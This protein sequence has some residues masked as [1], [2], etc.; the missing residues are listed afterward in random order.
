MKGNIKIEGIV[1]KVYDGD[2]PTADEIRLLLN[3]EPHSADAGLIISSADTIN[4]LASNNKA[5]V[6][7]QIGINCAP[8]PRNC[9]FCAFAAKNKVFGESMEVSFEDAV[10]MA[11]NGEREGKRH[12]YYG[13]R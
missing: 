13:N 3:V 9:S 10:M 4:R 7:A 12:I 1:N 6:H 2:Y 11:H 8:C 5:E